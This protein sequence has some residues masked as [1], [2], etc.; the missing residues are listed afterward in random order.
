VFFT[1]I[2]SVVLFLLSRAKNI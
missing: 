2:Y 1:I